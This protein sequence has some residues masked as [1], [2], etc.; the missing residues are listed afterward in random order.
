MAYPKNN[1]NQKSGQPKKHSGAKLSTYFTKEG[2]NKGLE[3]RIV[4]A[5]RLSR[6]GELI[7]V[8]CQTTGKSSLSDK[9]WY[10]SIAC[11]FINT[12]TGAKF[13]YWGTMHKATGKTV[14]ADVGIVVNPKAPNGGYCGTFSRK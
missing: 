13:F 8:T 11:T 9:G 7:K 4:N 3:Q 10:G 6:T 12:V 14:I 1:N 2:K 5:W